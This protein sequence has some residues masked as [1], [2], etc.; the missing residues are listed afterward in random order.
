MLEVIEDEQHAPAERTE[1]PSR[2]FDR[3]QWRVQLGFERAQNATLGRLDGAAI[4]GDG[5]GAAGARFTEKALEESRL[6]DPRKAVEV[7]DDRQ[8]ARQHCAEALQLGRP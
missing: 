1:L 2:L 5:S 8:D 4:E 3:Q 7:G 6:P